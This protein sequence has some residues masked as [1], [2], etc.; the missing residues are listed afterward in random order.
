MRVYIYCNRENLDKLIEKFKNFPTSVFAHAFFEE[1]GEIAADKM[2]EIA[3]GMFG[4]SWSDKSN[5]TGRLLS[6]IIIDVGPNSVKVGPPSARVPYAPFLEYG[7]MPHI[8]R[9]VNASVLHFFSGGKEIFAKEVHHPGFAGR[10]FV[11][12]TKDAVKKEVFELA[13][14]YILNLFKT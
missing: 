6:N 12:Q 5:R 14:T 3:F 4:S 1:A 9:P 10:F 7:T 13:V 8:I 11:R 2:R